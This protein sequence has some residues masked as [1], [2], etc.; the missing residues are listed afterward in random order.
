MQLN[1]IEF[2]SYLTFIVSDAFKFEIIENHGYSD[3]FDFFIGNKNQAEASFD[4]TGSNSTI[5]GGCFC[6]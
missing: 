3:L 2:P 6:L 4:W 1:E 5:Q